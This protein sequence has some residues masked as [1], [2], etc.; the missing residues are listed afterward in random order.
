MYIICASC[1]YSNLPTW[2][3]WRRLPRVVSQLETTIEKKLLV[4]HVLCSFP[5][6]GHKHLLSS[7]LEWEGGLGCINKAY[8]SAWLENV[9]LNEDGY[10]KDTGER[11]WVKHFEIVRNR[12]DFSGLVP[13]EEQRLPSFIL[14]FWAIPKILG[15]I[16]WI[17]IN[18]FLCTIFLNFNCSSEQ[19]GNIAVLYV[20]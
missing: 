15:T 5:S 19:K 6:A 16:L 17:S 3:T 1:S 12:S 8:I 7:E 13:E 14:F 11:E 4:E 2:K 9:W 10:F 20:R 18:A